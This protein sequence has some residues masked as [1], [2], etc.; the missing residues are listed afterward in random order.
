MKRL[1]LWLSPDL[2]NVV[3]EVVDVVVE[4]VVV[5]VVEVAVVVVVE[6]VVDSDVAVRYPVNCKI[7][8]KQKHV[9]ACYMILNQEKS[10]YYLNVI[11]HRFCT[12]STSKM[13]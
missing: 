7:S 5:V 2:D 11:Y 6:V 1:F 13:P 12:H 4:V 9:K 10:S 3:V 8:Y